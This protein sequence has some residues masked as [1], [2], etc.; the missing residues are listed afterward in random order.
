MSK[1][2]KI[3][4]NS[5]YSRALTGF[6]KN[7]KNILREL[8]KDKRFEIVEAA[9]GVSFAADLKTPWKSYGT[10]PKDPQTLQ[11]IEGDEQ[12]K[13]LAEYGNFTI[14]EIVKMEKPDIVLGVEDVWA[15]DWAKKKWFDKLNTVIWT[16][17]D[18][19][20]I[21]DQAYWLAPKVDKFLVWASFAEEEMSKRGFDVETIHGAIDYSSFYPILEPERS[22]LR[23]KFGLDDNFVIGFVFKNQLRKSVPNILEGF[24]LFKE[25]EEGKNAKLLLHTDWPSNGNSWD[26]EKYINELNVDKNDV[27]ATYIC[28]SCLEYHVKP[29]VGEE[30]DCQFC[31]TEKGCVTKNNGFGVSEEQLNEIYNLMDVYCHPFTSG[32]QELPI[33][34]AKAAGLI[35][36]VTE[37]SCGTDSCYEK[38][39]GIPLK[40]VSYR[41]PFTRFIKATTLPSSIQENLQRVKNLSKE[42]KGVLVQN[43]LNCVS[44]KFS[45]EKT[46][47]RLKTIFLELGKT[48]WDFNFEEDIP[49][50]DFQPEARDKD[51]DQD[52]VIYVY[53]G[54]FNKKLKKEDIEVKKACEIIKENGRE[55]ILRFLKRTAEEKKREL[56]RKELKL[57]DFFTEEDEKRVI[58]V[59]PESAGDVLLVNSLISNLKQKYKDSKIYFVTDPR[60]YPMIDSHPD[61]ENLIPYKQGMD[62]LLFWEGRGGWRGHSEVAFLPFVG[63]QRCLN[64]LHGQES[65]EF[66][67]NLYS[68]NFPK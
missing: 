56:T 65:E 40:W 34:E 62:N 26:I 64:Y 15:F 63:S 28:K 43:G 21:L 3:L 52:W 10:Y 54:F 41:E 49:N 35:T 30:I 6:G 57:E 61:I 9:N 32:G 50:C 11:S 29:Y 45:V 44:E 31:G 8:S 47:E 38:D 39:G 37:Y 2:I 1:K 68:E 22:D 53:E 27:L 66:Q 55:A 18:S 12:K 24:K 42:E 16:T 17:L 14:D 46:V 19:S 5:N 7:A 60:F 23:K 33:Q 25:T 4:F 48:D 13:R 67:F 20:P 59:M 36:L 51:S 58:V